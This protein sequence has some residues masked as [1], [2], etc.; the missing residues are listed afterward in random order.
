MITQDEIVISGPKLTNISAE[1]VA[2]VLR[3]GL[4]L[5]VGRVARALRDGLGLSAERVTRVIHG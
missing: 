1:R 4:D 2:Q 3:D 5:T